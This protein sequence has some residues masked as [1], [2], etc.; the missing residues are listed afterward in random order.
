MNEGERVGTLLAFS[1][2]FLC[3]LVITL[4]EIVLFLAKYSSTL[5][6]S[7]DKIFYLINGYT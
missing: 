1:F 6:S 5:R 7:I 3:I 4:I 2:F